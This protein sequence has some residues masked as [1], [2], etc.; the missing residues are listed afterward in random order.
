M[1]NTLPTGI[2]SIVLIILQGCAMTTGTTSHTFQKTLT[3]IPAADPVLDHYIAW[4]QLWNNE[5]ML[6]QASFVEGALGNQPEQLEVDFY[7][8]P[9]R[10]MKLIANAFCTKHGLW[11]SEEVKVEVSE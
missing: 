3:D 5:K 9:K 6:G 11:Q 1:G 8:V 10:N 2:I 4:I 7:I